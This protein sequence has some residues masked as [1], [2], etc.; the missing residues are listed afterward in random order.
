MIDANGT[1]CAAALSI[2]LDEKCPNTL[3][4]KI[5]ENKALPIGTSAR[6]DGQV[7]NH[8]AVAVETLEDVLALGYEVVEVIVQDEYTHDVVMRDRDRFLV[9]DTT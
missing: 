3:V 5:N 6:I 9:Y 1:P 7:C 8:Q 4:M 2:A